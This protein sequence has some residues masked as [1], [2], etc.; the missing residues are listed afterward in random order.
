VRRI[1]PSAVE[2]TLAFLA[3]PFRTNLERSGDLIATEIV[4][5]DAEPAASPGELVL[6]HP[7]IDPISY[8]WEWTIAQWSAAAEFTLR[9]AGRAIDAGWNLTDATPL[10]ILFQGPRPIL[11]EVLS[12]ERRDPASSLWVAYAQ[13]VRMFLLPLV[14]AKYLHRPLQATMLWQDGYEPASVYRALQPWQ[15]LYPNL[16]DV[17]TMATLFENFGKKP[18]KPRDP[19]ADPDPELILH[20]LHRRLARLDKQIRHAA[21]FDRSTRWSDHDKTA[22]RDKASDAAATEQFV[23]AALDRGKPAQVLDIGANTGAYS[24]LAAHTGARVTAIDHDP[25]ALGVLWREADRQKLSI[26]TIVANIARPSPATGWRNQEQL[27]LLD[28]L[29]DK[30]EMVLMR[31]VIYR[32]ILRERVPLTGIVELCTALTR[33]WLVVEW[34]PPS[35]P[36]YKEWLRGRDRLTGGLS[37]DDLKDAFA[38]S[39]NLVDRT[40]LENERVLLL[41]ERSH[42]PEPGT[43]QP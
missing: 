25:E 6:R 30:F 42:P 28:R 31:A 15:R 40:L 34:M 14:A 3:S 12:F 38:A 21:S 32:L 29:V 5:D 37:E 9:M 7:R 17:V 27:S 23:R 24:L 16:V 10:N 8:P 43:N 35:D 26:T 22:T 19:P 20:T 39:F 18:V 4:P 13:F 2:S 33:R 36:M 41:F 1:H 11:V